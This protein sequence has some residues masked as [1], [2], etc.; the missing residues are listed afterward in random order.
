MNVELN[1]KSIRHLPLWGSLGPLFFAASLYISTAAA[2]L[3]LWL[4]FTAIAC[5]AAAYKRKMASL[6]TSSAL[7]TSAGIT[8]YA[9]TPIGVG[10]F[11]LIMLSFALPILI[12]A[13]A[14]EQID[15]ATDEIIADANTRAAELDELQQSQETLRTK[16]HE[17]LLHKELFARDNDILEN[18]NVELETYKL[19]SELLILQLQ[20]Q[21]SELDERTD[22]QLKML[23]DAFQEI[24]TL[25]EE[26]EKTILKAQENQLADEQDECEWENT[27]LATDRELKLLERQYD[28]DIQD[29]H[30]LVLTLMEISPPLAAQPTAT[31]FLEASGEALAN[32]D[33]ETA[34]VVETESIPQPVQIASQLQD[35]DKK[36]SRKSPRPPLPQSEKASTYHKASATNKNPSVSSPKAKESSPS[37]EA[38]KTSDKSKSNPDK[39]K[40]TN[41][42]ANAILSRWSS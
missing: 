28:R 15:T 26:N 40:K 39:L 34:T 13:L 12:T 37:A 16:Y 3:P 9:N 24:E 35:A 5:V 14:F 2:T 27:L 30:D 8:F 32:M 7:L 38:A 10:V 11:T 29:L 31:P 22:E 19:R 4:V 17:S 1:A 33:M 41:V 21:V 6:W 42:W 25:Q 23:E 18:T 36:I 20:E